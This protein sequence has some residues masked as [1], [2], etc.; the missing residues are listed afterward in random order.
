MLNQ[1]APARKSTLP[2]LRELRDLDKPVSRRPRPA[3]LFPQP[4]G[5]E[6]TEQSRQNDSR[7]VD[8]I[9]YDD[10]ATVA[11]VQSEAETVV[12]KN[13]RP[14]RKA[15]RSVLPT[16]TEGFNRQG[17]A[18]IK[19]IQEDESDEEGNRH[20]EGTNTVHREVDQSD[21]AIAYFPDDDFSTCAFGG[22]RERGVSGSSPNKN[23]Q[24]SDK[25]E[26][27]VNDEA[28][29]R[30]LFQESV[31][32]AII[33]THT[34][35][36]TPD[37]PQPSSTPPAA[38]AH[39]DED[40]ALARMTGILCVCGLPRELTISVLCHEAVHAWLRLHPDTDVLKPILPAVEEGCCQ[41]VA[42]LLLEALDR[43]EK[44]GRDSLL[45]SVSRNKQLRQQL[46]LRIESDESD[47]F[48]QGYRVAAQ[49]CS[50]V[51][52]DVLM[53]NVAIHRDI[54]R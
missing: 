13:T 5:H 3:Q 18:P 46:K 26:Q 42:H 49:A 48:G 16:T 21:S 47:I 27:E 30:K 54:I 19:T 17:L 34:R 8:A 41:L 12:H 20:Q 2:T 52:I 40:E 7:D 9:G 22:T 44:M 45:G 37:P 51:G 15:T 14:S 10:D 23:I 31:E 50:N 53:G 29:A 6:S 11:T 24:A 39:I 32:E 28:L 4:S 33:N 25:K 38:A 36:P 1:Q 43:A 35:R